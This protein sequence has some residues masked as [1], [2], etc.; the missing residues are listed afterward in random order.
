MALRSL[1]SAQKQIPPRLA[2]TPDRPRRQ[3]CQPIESGAI[4]LYTYLGERPKVLPKRAIERIPLYEWLDVADGRLCPM[5]GQVHPFIRLE[6]EQDRAYYAE[7]LH[8]ARRAGS[9]RAGS[10]L[11]AREYVRRTLCRSPTCHFL[12]L[13]MGRQTPAP[14]VSTCRFPSR[15]PSLV[16]ALMVAPRHQARHDRC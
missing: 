16:N 1:R 6:N 5:P 4:L 8:G 12:G 3:P 9:M 2:S 7:T 13:G 10:P 15:C 14:Q 11:A